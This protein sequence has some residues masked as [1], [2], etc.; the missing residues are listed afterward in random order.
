ME[1]TTVAISA[2]NLTVQVRSE[3]IH[4]KFIFLAANSDLSCHRYE[5]GESGRI[6]TP[7]FPSSYKA[8]ATC[9]WVLEGPINSK[10]QV[11]DGLQ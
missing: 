9:L 1:S 6:E 3:R 11:L 2:M 7:N 8:G 5:K 4:P 10:I